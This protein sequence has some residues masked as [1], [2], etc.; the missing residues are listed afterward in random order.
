MLDQD[1]CRARRDLYSAGLA[2]VSYVACDH[3]LFPDVPASG[4]VNICVYQAEALVV[5]E[6]THMEAI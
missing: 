3:H 1:I 6:P 5:R 4:L 2:I